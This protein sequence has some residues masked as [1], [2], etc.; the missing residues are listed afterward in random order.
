MPC[1]NRYDL[2]MVDGLEQQ[3]HL[4]PH[5][6][7]EAHYATRNN[8]L[9]PA[10]VWKLRGD[11]LLRED[12]KGPPRAVTLGDVKAVQMEFAPTRPERNRYRC[13]ITLSNATR[14]ELLN[15]TYRGV[16]DFADTSTEY[17]EFM[18]A[19]HAGLA[20]H[21]PG[22]QFVAGASGA[23]YAVNIA[24]LLLVLAVVIGA[25]GF[26]LVAG[27]LWVVLIKMVL[28]VFYLPSAIKW[29]KS[30]KPKQYRPSAIPKDM[31]PQ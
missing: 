30:N 20:R 28:I 27:M 2:G 26:F 12:G 21:S 22:C 10:V 29:V 14:L 7:A 31:L 24:V 4:P 3:E 23:S 17:N 1:G 16:Y 5:L 18:R 15:R 9:T 19:L 25:I 11:R 8:A 6:D 13:R